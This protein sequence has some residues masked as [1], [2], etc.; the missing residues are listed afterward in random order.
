MRLRPQ[1]YL[2]VGSGTEFNL[3]DKIPDLKFLGLDGSPVVNNAYTDNNGVDGSVLNYSTFSR[4][5]IT[6]NFYMHFSDWRNFQGLKDRIY[7]LFD[8]RQVIRLRTDAQPNMVIYVRSTSFDIKQTM[9]RSQ[10]TTISI[11]FDN[12]TGYKYSL[13]RTDAMTDLFDDYP[14]GYDIPIQT[15]DDYYATG[16]SITI[17]NG[18]DVAIDP[19][20]QHHDLKVKIHYAGDEL[21]IYNHTNDS[22]WRLTKTL[23]KS[24]VVLID[25]IDTYVNGTLATDST[26]YNTLVLDVGQNDLAIG[27][28][29]DFD[30]T[31]SFPYVFLD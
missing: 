2:Q 12:P 9:D 25:G 1:L 20:Y 21:A 6:A 27:G 14:L 24:D 11:V 5:T 17:L 28:S 29:S 3:N 10:D 16:N 22:S 30:V 8:N 19:Y 4:S 13:L 23:T 7:K 26:D 31:F 15:A 18:G